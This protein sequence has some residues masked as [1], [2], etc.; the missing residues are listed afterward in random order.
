MTRSGTRWCGWSL[1]ELLS[2]SIPRDGSSGDAGYSPVTIA[3]R[4]AP[5]Y[6]GRIIT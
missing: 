3:V 4:L 1:D 5:T 6:T 2:E